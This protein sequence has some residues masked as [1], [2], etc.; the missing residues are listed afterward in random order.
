MISSK[1]LNKI[2][3]DETLR[4]KEHEEVAFENLF[5]RRI[6]TTFRIIRCEW[7]FFKSFLNN[8]IQILQKYEQFHEQ[9]NFFFQN[10]G[11]ILITEYFNANT[12]NSEKLNFER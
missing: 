4:D 3:T 9:K 2:I 12:V 11:H 7:Q 5:Q 8:V 6:I 10:C 1:Y